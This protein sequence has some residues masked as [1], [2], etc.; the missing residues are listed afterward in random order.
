MTHLDA[1]GK[2]LSGVFKVPTSGMQGP[3]A[4]MGPGHAHILRPKAGRQAGD[5]LRCT[6]Q[7]AQ[8]LLQLCS[9]PGSLMCLGAG[10]PLF[11]LLQ[12]CSGVRDSCTPSGPKLAVR[13]LMACAAPLSQLRTLLSCALERGNPYSGSCTAAAGFGRSAFRPKAGLQ[14]GDGLRCTPQPAQPAVR[15]WALPF[16]AC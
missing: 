14:A 3:Q 16:A 9:G 4:R 13:H 10:S 15:V 6:P 2:V 8:D 12:R 7:P 1:V 11:W 5:G